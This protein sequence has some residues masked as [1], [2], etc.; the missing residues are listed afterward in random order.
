MGRRS[1]LSC[2]VFA[3]FAISVFSGAQTLKPLVSF[4]GANGYTP[5]AGLV[6]GTN[7]NFYGATASGGANN[8]GTVYEITPRGMLKAQKESDL[9]SFRGGRMGF[10]PK[11]ELYAPMTGSYTALRVLAEPTTGGAYSS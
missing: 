8:N 2:T 7:G 9:Y 5:Y 3:V 6:Q 10:F 4:N 11:P 1:L